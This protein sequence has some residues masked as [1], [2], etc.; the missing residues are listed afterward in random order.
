MLA[1]DGLI[2]TAPK[3]QP[4]GSALNPAGAH[5]CFDGFPQGATG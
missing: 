1:T 3:L 5:P 2:V 4:E